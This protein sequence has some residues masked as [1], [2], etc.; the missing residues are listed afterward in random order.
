MVLGQQEEAWPG[1][2]AGGAAVNGVGMCRECGGP[3][4]PLTPGGRLMLHPVQV[5]RGRRIVDGSQWC[6]GGGGLP[7]EFHQRQMVAA[8]EAERFTRVPEFKA[9]PPVPVSPA[10]RAWL[11]RVDSRRV[12]QSL[13]GQALLRH[14]D[15]SGAS[16]VRVKTLNG[17][18]DRG[19]I[20]L[21]P[22][23]VYELTT[24]GVLASGIAETE[25]A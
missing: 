16:V 8:L 24:A 17:L 3:N 22:A 11:R 18:L 10:E 15:N 9:A 7:E 13:K 14:T 25:A 21:N 2:A 1:V 5:V 23:G 4:L 12:Y 19:L 20:R 6:E